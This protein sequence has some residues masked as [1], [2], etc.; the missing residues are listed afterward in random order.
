MWNAFIAYRRDWVRIRLVLTVD[1]ILRKHQSRLLL[2]VIN[3]GNMAVSIVAVKMIHVG[4]DKAE[5]PIFGDQLAEFALCKKLEPRTASA[6]RAYAGYDPF[7]LGVRN[8]YCKTE[9][10]KL[11][12]INRRMLRN[13]KAK[14][15]AA[16]E[17]DKAANSRETLASDV[18]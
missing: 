3:P 14:L 6:T 4:I 7:F 1:P 17:M 12:R 11:F 2:K 16:L 10:G 18:E 9:C 13:A 5:L 8:I 15:N